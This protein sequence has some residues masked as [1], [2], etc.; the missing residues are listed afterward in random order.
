MSN[1]FEIQININMPMLKDRNG[2]ASM[3]Y[4]ACEDVV[5]Q[6]VAHGIPAIGENYSET[7]GMAAGEITV[8]LARVS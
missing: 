6:M 8:T 5:A 3:I 4:E 2:I 7:F 1:N